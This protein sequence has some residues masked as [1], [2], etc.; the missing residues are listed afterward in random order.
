MVEHASHEVSQKLHRAARV[1]PQ[2]QY[3][4]V[5]GSDLVE[6]ILGFVGWKDEVWQF[7]DDGILSVLN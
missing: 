2:V 7:P 5:V 6:H 4:S 3:Q 1:A